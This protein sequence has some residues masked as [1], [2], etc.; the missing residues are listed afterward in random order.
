MYPADPARSDDPRSRAARTKRNRTRQALL[1]AAEAIFGSQ[2]W[3]NARMEDIAAAAGVS[4]ATVYNH[5]PSKLAL[6]GHAFAPLL[7]T[8]L[9]QA[10]HDVVADRPA[11][12]ALNEQLR[13]L[14]EIVFQHRR[15][16]AAL[17]AAAN[18]HRIRVADAGGPEDRLDPLVQAPIGHIVRLLVEHGQR[19]GQLRRYPPAVSISR[20]IVNMLLLS[21]VDLAQD[22]PEGVAEL[23]L[24]V[25]FG[26]LRPELV[27]DAGPNDRPFEH[28]LHHPNGRSFR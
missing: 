17:W 18:E 28:G 9:A 26:T 13:A 5:F 20:Q 12:E 25:L 6:I 24:T 3:R 22:D 21:C 8:Q 2:S 4:L 1:A 10:E 11:V 7:S 16:A 23:L 27:L 15:L 19:T 14:T